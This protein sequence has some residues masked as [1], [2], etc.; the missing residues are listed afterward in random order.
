[1]KT[2]GW[3]EVLYSECVMMGDWDSYN[4]CFAVIL[5]LFPYFPVIAEVPFFILLYVIFLA[6]Y[7]LILNYKYGGSRKSC[8]L[9]YCVYVDM[10]T[11]DLT[12][13]LPRI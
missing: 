6:D 13:Y 10:E 1:M 11:V 12:L 9:L 5:G 8:P 7:I 4:A 2:I 3:T